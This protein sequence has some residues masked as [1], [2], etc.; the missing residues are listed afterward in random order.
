MAAVFDLGLDACVFSGFCIM[1]L[2][3]DISVVLAAPNLHLQDLHLQVLVIQAAPSRGQR[4]AAG[5]QTQIHL[6][7]TLCCVFVI[8]L[9]R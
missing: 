2:G 6:D 4:M 3:S 7:S 5:V 1:Q 9:S 8:V